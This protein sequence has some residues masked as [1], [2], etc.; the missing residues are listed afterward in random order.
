MVAT[1]RNHALQFWEQDRKVGVGADDHSRRLDRPSTRLHQH[2]PLSS[3]RVS[4]LQHR[5]VGL[6]I[7]AGRLKG[8]VSIKERSAVVLRADRDDDSPELHVQA[9]WL[10][11]Q[12][13]FSLLRC[14][15]PRRRTL[16]RWPEQ[17]A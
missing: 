9:V 5:T 13:G 1:R 12:G 2:A 3:L 14:A 10:S 11:S 8:C 16:P 15:Q 17:A 4:D 6:Q 7:R